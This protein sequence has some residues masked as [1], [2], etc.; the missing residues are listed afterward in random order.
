MQKW[1]LD[2][3]DMLAYVSDV[4][5]SAWIRRDCERRFRG[6]A[7]DATAASLMSQG[8]IPVLPF[9]ILV[10]PAVKKM[11][12]HRLLNLPSRLTA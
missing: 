3:G 2:V 9:L 7:P 10:I 4:L 6:L 5:S 12:Q 8:K 1:Y 11:G